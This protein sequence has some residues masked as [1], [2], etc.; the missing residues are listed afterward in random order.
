MPTSARRKAGSG[1][2]VIRYLR[3][4][5]SPLTDV[6]PVVEMRLS[7]K[8]RS[9]LVWML[10]DTGATVSIVPPSVAEELQLETKPLPHPVKGVGGSVAVRT[11]KVHAQLVRPD[12]TGRLGPSWLLD[13]LMVAPSEETLP[14]PLLGRKPFLLHHELTV[15]EDRQEFVLREGRR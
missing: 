4:D 1:A 11:S 10:M 2:F 7:W 5:L 6:A 8:G 3:V 12:T 15:R 13:P 9:Q 14:M